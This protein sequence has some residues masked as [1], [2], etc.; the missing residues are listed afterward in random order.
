MPLH[1]NVE[2]LKEIVMDPI[3][4]HKLGGEDILGIWTNSLSRYEPNNAEEG[5]DMASY[6]KTVYDI[7]SDAFKGWKMYQESITTTKDL[8]E[9]IF[10]KLKDSAFDAEA[11][12]PE[13]CE[14][15]KYCPDRQ[16]ACLNMVYS[17]LY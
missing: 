16:I 14:A 5:K 17:T 10:M 12:V 7:D 2:K 15:I 9:A 4:Y 3:P 8:I 11:Y 6:I 1:W 13:I